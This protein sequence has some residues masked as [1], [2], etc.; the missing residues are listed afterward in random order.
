MA[1][2]D[3][4]EVDIGGLSDCYYVDTGMYGVPEY[5]SVYVL[6]GD[7]PA[8]VD[9]GIGTH[10]DRVLAA[11]EELGIA[12]EDLATLA[13]TH[14]HL[15]HAGGAGFLAEACE[16]ATV[17]VHSRG[18][19]HLVDPGRLWAGTKQAVGDQIE[20]YT[21][22]E[23]VA[24]D[25]IRQ[26]EDG[27]ELDLGDRTLRVHHAPGHAPHQVVFEDPDASAVFTADAGGI[28]VPA[29]DALEPTT[30]PPQFDL[31]LALEDV[32]TIEGLDPD[33]LCYAHFGPA[34]P[35]NRLDEYRVTLAEWVDAV[36]EMRAEL[37]DD[38]AVIDR[39]VE[40]QDIGE[41]WGERK[42]RGETAMNVRGVLA[43]LDHAD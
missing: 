22:P 39:F 33:V 38:E 23:P 5:G 31:D 34:D 10:H 28:Y 2:G 26:V 8:L 18:A 24:E 42:A 9:T 35:G 7:R 6:D 25:R 19:R 15:D 21:E 17:A 13:V 1:P 32:D 37:G 12:R 27:D 29:L 30:P 3:V 16:N 20:Y 11:L 40:T 41:V 36:R 14:V 43:Y 4:F